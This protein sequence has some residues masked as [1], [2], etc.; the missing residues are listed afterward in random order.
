MHMRVLY[1]CDECFVLCV[2][3]LY[4]F[5]VSVVPAVCVC[6]SACCGCS[7]YAM[8]AVVCVVRFLVLPV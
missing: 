1:R 2:P 3:V 5:V 8:R 7:A 4:A 6:V